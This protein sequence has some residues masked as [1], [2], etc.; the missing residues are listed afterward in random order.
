M[1]KTLTSGFLAVCQMAQLMR[2][3]P[4]HKCHCTWFG[5]IRFLREPFPS[6]AQWKKDSDTLHNVLWTFCL[7]FKGTRGM[8]DKKR[9]ILEPAL[10]MHSDLG[11]YWAWIPKWNHNYTC[12]RTKLPLPASPQ[13][14]LC[15]SWEKSQPQDSNLTLSLQWGTARQLPPGLSL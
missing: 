1:L 15:S 8:S 11:W 5:W 7:I 13:L 3:C 9:C 14:C 12:E 10:L 2:Q 4:L 6:L